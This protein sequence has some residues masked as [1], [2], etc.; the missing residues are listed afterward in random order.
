MF[1]LLPQGTLCTLLR[2]TSHTS[3][4]ITSPL[5]CDSI[6]RCTMP[7]VSRSL[8]LSITT[9]SLWTGV[10]RMTPSSGSSSTFVR[11]LREPL[12]STAKVSFLTYNDKYIVER[13]T[14]SCLYKLCSL[15][16]FLQNFDTVATF[17]PFSGSGENWHSDWLLYDETLPTDCCRGHRLDTDLPT[18][19]YH[20]TSAELC[21]RVG[22]HCSKTLT[23]SLISKYFSI[24]KGCQKYW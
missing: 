20:W 4:I 18:R 3:G 19:V 2:P 17:L 10:H 6:R 21:W 16:G 14:C 23:T 13:H 12:L 7:G 5:S 9:C 1:F 22:V 8:G 24:I 11:M 15:S